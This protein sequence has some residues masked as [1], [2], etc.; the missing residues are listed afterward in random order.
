MARS[1]RLF[2]EVQESKGLSFIPNTLSYCIGQTG[3]HIFYSFCITGN[4]R[5]FCR[6]RPLNK[7]EVS[8][9]CK[10]II[11]FDAARDGEIGIL[12]GAA[13]KKTFKFDH[14]FNPKDDQ[15]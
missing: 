8:S 4:I 13:T 3:N 9:G 7:D 12:T 11:D 1:R 15:G 2:N 6:C 10:A 5:V 14:I